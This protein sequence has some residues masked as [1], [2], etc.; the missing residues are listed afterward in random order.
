[1]ENGENIIKKEFDS[2]DVMYG[3]FIGR[4]VNAD[5]FGKRK[6][7]FT[8]KSSTKIKND[9]KKRK[10]KDIAGKDKVKIYKKKK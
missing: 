9:M 1:M 2:Y 5:P 8:G 3:D 6:K 7:A 4:Y 10:T